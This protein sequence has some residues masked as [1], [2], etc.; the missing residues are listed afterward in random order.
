MISVFD[1]SNILTMSFSNISNLFKFFFRHSYYCGPYS[2]DVW[3][4]EKLSPSGDRFD[5]RMSLLVAMIS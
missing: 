3:K 4:D 1:S 2:K 5:D